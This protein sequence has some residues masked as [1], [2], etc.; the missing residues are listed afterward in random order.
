MLDGLACT[1]TPLPYAWCA[2]RVGGYR[3]RADERSP[4]PWSCTSL[5]YFHGGGYNADPP[6]RCTMSWLRMSIN[7]VTFDVH[8]AATWGA[9]A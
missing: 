2:P 7:G 8:P 9:C 6:P 3:T 5:D 4:G 1:H